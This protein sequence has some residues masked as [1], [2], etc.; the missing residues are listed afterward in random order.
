MKTKL[1]PPESAPKDLTVFLGEFG[2]CYL[3]PTVWNPHDE[4]WVTATVQACGM[5]SG[6]DDVYFSSE[7]ERECDLKGW[8]PLP[9]T[10]Q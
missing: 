2:W 5:D 7:T 10:K 8:L 3:L 4:K 6:H 1:N 9:T